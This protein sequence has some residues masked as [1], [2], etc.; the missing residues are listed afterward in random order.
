MLSLTNRSSLQSCWKVFLNFSCY[1]NF[2]ILHFNYS[3]TNIVYDI[4]LLFIIV[5]LNFL[6]GLFDML[7]F[8]STDTQARNALW[9][10]MARI[11]PH[12]NMYEIRSMLYLQKY[13]TIFIEKGHLIEED[14]DEHPVQSGSRKNKESNISN[15]QNPDMITPSVSSC[16]N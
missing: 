4:L 14:L 9:S 12:I 10:I 11:F 16:L 8:V 2:Y 15:I 5:D 6:Q 1:V 3:T 13:V 7:P